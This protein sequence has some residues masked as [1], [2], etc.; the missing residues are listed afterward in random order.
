MISTKETI[1]VKELLVKAIE[2]LETNVKLAKLKLINKG[3]SITSAFLAY[4]IISLF[5]LMMIIMLS[6]GAALWIGK[7]LGETYYG[8]L[9]IGGFFLLLILLLYSLRNKWLKIPIANSLLQNLYK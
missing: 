1:T 3:S 9:I 7:V 2:Y 8:F 5:V 6:I 4:A